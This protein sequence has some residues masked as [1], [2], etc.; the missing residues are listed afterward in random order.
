VGNCIEHNSFFKAIDTEDI[1]NIEA[2]IKCSKELTLPPPEKLVVPKGPKSDD[3]LNRKVHSF[4]ELFLP[5]QLIYLSE[6]K[7][8]L[9]TIPERHLLWMALLVSTSLE[10]NSILCGY[11]GS[12]KRRPGAIR[13]VFAHHAYSFPYTALENN[14]VFSGNT[15]GTL[16]RLFNSRVFIASKWAKAPI[17]RKYIDGKWVKTTIYGE[18]D[19]GQE[20]TSTSAFKGQSRLFLVEQNDSSKIPQPDKVVDFVVT[21]PPY[22]DSVQYSDLSY[23]FRCWLSWFLPHCVDWNY[24][25]KSSAVAESEKSKLKFGDVLTNIWKECSR[26]LARP[27]GRL[28][29]TFHH[30]KAS[31]WTQLSFSLAKARFRLVN[32]YVVHAE[33]PLS[34]HIMNMKSLKH[35]TILVL[36]PVDKQNEKQWEIP[37]TISMEDSYSF[38]QGCAQVLGWVLDNDLAYDT[39]SKTWRKFLEAE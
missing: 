29:F 10:F 9:D 14:P 39:I 28:I 3:L 32:F 33:N 23:F 24:L 6:A 2:A 16:S 31:A 20:C 11:K 30:W 18:S 25:V 19:I 8:L 4:S 13:H 27:H 17:E 37:E 35:D 5:R 26:V 22:Y 7:R 36:R 38:C 34:V 21:D 15:S 1:Q 12:E